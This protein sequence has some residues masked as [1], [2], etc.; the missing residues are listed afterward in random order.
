MPE[1]VCKALAVAAPNLDPSQINRLFFSNCGIS[2]PSFAAILRGVSQLRD[3]KSIVYKLN[4]FGT[5]SVQALRPLFE[6]NVPFHLEQLKLVDLKTT[7]KAIEDLLKLMHELCY[8]G[9]VS[10]VNLRMTH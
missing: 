4:Q 7:T 10:L 8:L 5:E 6:K 1:G 3:F 2:D 9:S